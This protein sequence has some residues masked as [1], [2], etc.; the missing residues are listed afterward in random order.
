MKSY[1]PNCLSPPLSS[2]LS[3]TKWLGSGRVGDRKS[4]VVAF[5][6]CPFSA[7]RNRLEQPP[8]LGW[9]IQPNNLLPVLPCCQ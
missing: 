4:L 9:A 1:Q 5:I 8:H 6:G 2:R 3:I 7:A